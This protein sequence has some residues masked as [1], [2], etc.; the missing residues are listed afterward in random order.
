MPD[1]GVVLTRN[2]LHF[3]RILR[4]LGFDAGPARMLPFLTALT[5]IELRRPDD[6]RTAVHAH[7]GR[8]RDE[9]PILDRALA[10]FL[11]AQTADRDTP[12]S[13]GSTSSQRGAALTLAGR[14]LK[15]LDDM[16][17]AEGAEEQEVAS[18]SQVE[19]LRQK[20]FDT[21]TEAEMAE[22]R[23]L[24]RLMRLPAGL[25][26][27]RRARAGGHDQLDIRRLLRR[28]LRFGGELLVFSWKSPTLRPRPLVLLCDI[29][30]SMERYTRLLLNFAYA[31]K[32]AS[33]R[34]EAFVFATR[35]TRIT[36]LLRSHDVDAALNRV[37]ASV[38]DWSGGTR[39]GES[40]ET[41]NRR[42]ARRVLGHGATVAIISDGWDRGDAAQMR[43]AVARLQRSCHRLIWMNPLMGAPGY[44]PLTLGL[45]AALPF[46]DDFL[47]AHN[48]ANLEAL[49]VLLLKTAKRRPIRRQALLTASA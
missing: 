40:I 5:V 43:R 45:Q 2:W 10:A 1:P 48:L 38:D 35:L 32:S 26:R 37:M 3:G 18:Y 20:D 22:V 33:T 11:G 7:F 36:R 46:V 15:V 14:Q 41:F 21:L 47:P 29:S 28:S 24:I 49:G 8:R 44:E 9:L 31:L 39:I 4:G 27:S 16:E 23:R 42:Y 13:A 30:G 25:T 19:V 12:E 6:V 34:V 17:G